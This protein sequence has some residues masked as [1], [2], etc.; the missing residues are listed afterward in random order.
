MASVSCLGLCRQTAR[1][2]AGPGADARHHVPGERREERVHEAL[3]GAALGRARA[4]L[5]RGC[6][7]TAWVA[8]CWSR[9][10]RLG[11]GT[12][13]P[14]RRLDDSGVFGVVGHRGLAP[15]VRPGLA[16]ARGARRRAQGRRSGAW[17]PRGDA[18]DQGRRGRRAGRRCQVPGR[19]GGREGPARGLD[20][21]LRLL[22][23]AA[24]FAVRAQG[25]L[26]L[27][28]NN[29]FFGRRENTPP[30]T[31]IRKAGGPAPAVPPCI[32][33]KCVSLG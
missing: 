28:F 3:P 5:P 17:R 22:N 15:P 8:G 9:R 27:N 6:A 25:E 2:G 16:A 31:K 24:V 19:G 20:L 12:T 30:L 11:S 10:T 4:V 32:S 1:R 21:R 26:F 13:G 23:R 18:G 29:P 14:G 7:T 33:V